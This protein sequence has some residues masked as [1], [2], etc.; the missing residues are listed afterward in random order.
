MV[1]QYRVDQLQ[2]C[3]IDCDWLAGKYGKWYEK[4]ECH[5]EEFIEAVIAFEGEP[6]YAIG[7]VQGG[8]GGDVA[9]LLQRNLA[10][11]QQTFDDFCARRKV[12]YNIR[13]D[14]TPD[15]YEHAIH[16]LQKVI[17]KHEIQLRLI[18][19]LTQP[20]YIGARLADG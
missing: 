4:A 17:T 20:G 8:G 7:K 15:D 14:Y 13:A 1:E 5:L 3:A 9:S 6:A 16:F 2:L 18:S 10:F 11:A 19:G 12:A